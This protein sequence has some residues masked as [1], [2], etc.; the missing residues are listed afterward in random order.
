MASIVSD[1]KLR[2]KQNIKKKKDV[3]LI[4][5]DPNPYISPKE[6]AERWRCARSSV[7][8]IVRRAK[9]TRLLLGHG[10]NGIVRFIKREVEAYEVT[11]QI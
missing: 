2:H 10:K 9:L 7:D 4:D 8:R 1:S 5:D 6:L 11:R 3:T